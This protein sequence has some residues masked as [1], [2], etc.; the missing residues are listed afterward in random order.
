MIYLAPGLTSVGCLSDRSLLMN[1]ASDD[2]DG[3]NNYC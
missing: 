1:G 2:G 3:F